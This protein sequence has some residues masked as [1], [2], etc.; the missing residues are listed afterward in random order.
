MDLSEDEVVTSTRTFEKRDVRQFAEATGDRGDH[1]L[2]EDAEGRLLVHGL[3]TASLATEIGGRYNVLARTM[4][5]RFHEPVYAGETVRCETQFVT[6]EPRDDGG[7][8]EV[9]A[10]LRFVREDD[11][12]V[13]LTGS[14][15]GVIK[16]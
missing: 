3:L 13:V 7:G 1:H 12:A 10:E 4:E 5:Y 16:A 8:H 2:E 9:A 15:D 14:F 11:D 6:V